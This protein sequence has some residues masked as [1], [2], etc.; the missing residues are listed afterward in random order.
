M[1]RIFSA[2]IVLL[3]MGIIPLQAQVKEDKEGPGGNAA[4]HAIAD[5]TKRTDQYKAGKTRKNESA[6]VLFLIGDSPMKNGTGTGEGKMWG[7]GTF[8]G[9]FFYD[10]Q[11]SVENHALGGRSSRTFITQGL[12]ANVLSGIQKGDYLMVQFGHN[13]GG[14]LNTGRARASL[15]GIG[16]ESQTVVM[17]ATGKEETVYTF[18]HYMRQYIREAKAKGAIVI[19]LSL[20]PGNRWTGDKMNR[21]D[22]TYGLWTKQSA[23]QEGVFYF[24][25]ND[26][27]ARKFE[28]MGQEAAS[29]YYA[30][31][32]HTLYNGAILNCISALEGLKTIPTCS[33]N[34]FVNPEA[35]KTV[36]REKLVE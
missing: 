18:G 34:K 29:A 10:N 14:P 36:N 15:K 19:A 21:C 32:V 24:D 4:N 13:D 1:R 5:P 7:W 22:S 16:E 20:T 6:P 3:L 35:L 33:L 30:D 2:F 31:G 17:E 8:F 26:I 9:K 25:M 12:W 27:I 28:A 23:E 11:I